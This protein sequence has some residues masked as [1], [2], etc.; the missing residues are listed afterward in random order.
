MMASK[1]RRVKK[2]KTKSKG[3]LSAL[4]SKKNKGFKSQKGIG[5][6]FSGD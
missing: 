6:L 1:K 3:M 4:K 2:H 5:Q